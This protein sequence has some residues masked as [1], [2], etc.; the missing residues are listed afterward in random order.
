MRIHT[1]LDRATIEQ[2]ARSAG[3]GLLRLSEHG[4]RSAPRAFE[5]ILSGNGITGGQYGTLGGRSATWD[6]WGIFLGAL[7]RR[8]AQAK[9]GPYLNAEHFEWSTGGRYDLAFTPACQHLRHKWARTGHVVTGSYAVSECA[10]GAVQRW[11]T[12]GHTWADIAGETDAPTYV[13]PFAVVRGRDTN[14]CESSNVM[15]ELSAATPWV[16]RKRSA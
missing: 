2:A 6:E 5:V 1:R 11:L 7:Y 3:A 14:P 10:C 4:S 9:A 12:P 15:P 16:P 13:D 8:D